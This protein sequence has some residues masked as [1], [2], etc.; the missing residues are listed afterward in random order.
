MA[1]GEVGSTVGSP[2]DRSTAGLAEPLPW[3]HLP[4][5][6]QVELGPR[7][8]VER[9]TPITEE[10]W[11][12]HVGPE[13]R[14]QQVPELRARIFSGVRCWVGG[15]D[16]AGPAGGHGGPSELHACSAPQ[17]LCP[18]LRREAWK[19]LLGYLSWEGSAEEHKAHVRRKT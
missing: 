4:C 12:H 1:W 11:A 15:E 10:E 17:G 8:T 3:A 2:T 5:V 13:G 9:A 6:L 18:G 7:P 16:W 19:F 14:L